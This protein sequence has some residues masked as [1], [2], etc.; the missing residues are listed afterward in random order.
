MNKLATEEELKILMP[1]RIRR[2]RKALKLTQRE[3]AE[4]LDVHYMTVHGWEQ[5]GVLPSRGNLDRLARLLT[6]CRF[7]LE[8][9][10]TQDEK[11]LIRAAETGSLTAVEE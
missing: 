7:E 1:E 9:A 2:Y 3:V 8:K 10:P 5:P 6:T 4:Q 11:I